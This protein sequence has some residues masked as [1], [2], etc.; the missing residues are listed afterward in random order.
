MASSPLAIFDA[1]RPMPEVTPNDSSVDS[2]EHV[3]EFG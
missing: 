3:A 2:D 1:L